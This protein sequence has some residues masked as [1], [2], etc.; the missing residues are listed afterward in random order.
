MKRLVLYALLYGMFC[1]PNS[2]VAQKET[3]NEV[4]TLDDGFQDYFYEA[5]KQK[6]M[7]NYDKAIEALEKGKAIEPENPIVYFELGKNYLAQKKYKDAYDSFEKVTKI[8]SE[9]RWAWVGMYDVCYETHDYNQ[10]I[11]V[12]EKLV[13][14]KEDY[15]ED[16]MSLYMN[17]QQFGKALD[18]INELNEK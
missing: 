3:D 8:D 18:L 7:E 12:V 17:T 2:S 15:K 10:A 4:V 16:L 5:I 1:V 14:F 11:I 6:C 13:T 9:N